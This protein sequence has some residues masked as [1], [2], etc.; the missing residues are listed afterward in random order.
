MNG[1]QA[2]GYFMCP[3]IVSSYC[4]TNDT[5]GSTPVKYPVVR[6]VINGWACDNEKGNIAMV[7]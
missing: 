2:G 1:I 5:R 3:G 6:H 7:I 4:S